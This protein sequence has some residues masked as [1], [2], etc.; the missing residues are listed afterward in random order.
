M[1]YIGANYTQQLT[2]PAIDY[3][4]GNG[5]TTT[6]TL[7]RSVTSVFS[8][9]VVVNGVQQNPRN[10]YTINQAGNLVFD[11]APSTGTNNIYVMYNSQVGQFV[12]PS[13]GTVTAS[14]LAGGAVNSTMLDA[15]NFNGTGALVAPVGSTGQRPIG[16]I[17]GM[18]RFNSLTSGMEYYDGR[19]W[20]GMSEISS[21]ITAATGG[22]ITT[23]GNFRIHTFNSSDNFIV[24]TVIGAGTV[25]Y[26]IVAGGGGGGFAH[27][28]GGG[29]GGMLTGTVN[30][31]AGTY[32][33]TVGAGGSTDTTGLSTPRAG[34]NSSAFGITAFGGAGGTSGLNNAFN[35]ASFCPSGGSGG[36]G[37]NYPSLN[38]QLIGGQMG[39][40]GTSGQGNNGGHASYWDATNWGGGGGGGG[41]GFPGGAAPQGNG[42]TGG[43]GSGGSGRAS[44]ISGTSV[45]YAGGGGGGGHN[46][47]AGG[48]S[49]GGGIAGGSAGAAGSGTANTGGGG[50][51]GGSP[52][53]AA[54]N[55][56][57]ASGGSGIVILRYRFQ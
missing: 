36:G 23:S 14:S 42:P 34:N 3:F 24:N 22:T 49:G 33:I 51:G 43:G 38:Q 37:G 25:E 31:T 50:G 18:V 27:G 17:T 8:V 32:A 46:V 41:A 20:L 53:T 45:F 30:L 13:P 39:G 48:G 40:N 5:V 35:T 44:S 1:S 26:L 10:A 9:E 16:P 47:R 54:G 2:T 12:T 4:S 7:T 57:G 15:G 52:S 21:Y 55:Q 56:I 6:F 19:A 28:G 29:A 11:G